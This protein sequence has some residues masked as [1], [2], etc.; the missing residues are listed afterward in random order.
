MHPM[1]KSLAVL[2]CAPFAAC[3]TIVSTPPADCSAF[4]PPAWT[5]PVTGYPLPDFHE[6]DSA[7]DPVQAARAEAKA[8]QQFGVGQSGQL[9][10]ANG[11]QADTLHIFETCE[12]R[13]NAARPRRK[14][15]GIF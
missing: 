3:Q 2:L 6:A 14:F 11:R 4:I 1:K 8:W 10:K 7:P 9:A 5:N 15:L 13:I 12:N